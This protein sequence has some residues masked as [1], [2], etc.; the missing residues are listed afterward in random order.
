[1][2]ELPEVETIR[3]GLTARLIDFDIKNIEVCRE[4]AIASP[5]GPNEFIAGLRGARVGQ[6]NRRGKYLLA[7][8]YRKRVSDSLTLELKNQAGFWGVHLRMTGQFHWITTPI[9]PCSHTR[10]RIWNV[11]GQELRFVDT[12]SFGQMWWVPPGI[13][14]EKI[15]TGLKNLGPEPLSQNFNSNYLANCL[16]TKKKP[17][18]LALLDQSIAAGTGNIYADESLFIAGINP[19]KPSY[20]LNK[21]ELDKLCLSLKK[22]LKISIGEGGTT[23]K[24]FRDLEGVN[25]KYGGQAWVYRRTSQ[26][27][28]KCG[29]TIAKSK[30]AGRS[31]HWCPN[32]QV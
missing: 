21:L 15:I 9:P 19:L 17:I 20:Q 25:G 7:K 10:V 13:P 12:R 23:F 11:L 1:M 18:K 32:C 5:G 16:K 22:T 6:W 29:A 2:P 27:C 8:L 31:T 28:R 4:R 30:L 14:P 24:D 26:P 3:R